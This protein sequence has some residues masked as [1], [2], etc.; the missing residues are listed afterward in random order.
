[1]A[2][3][4]RG[5]PVALARRG[6]AAGAR[7]GRGQHQQPAGD[8]RRRRSTLRRARGGTGAAELSPL[9]ARERAA[10]RPPRPIGRRALPHRRRARLRRGPAVL[11]RGRAPARLRDRLDRGRRRAGGPIQDGAW[12]RTITALCLHLELD[13]LLSN[14]AFGAVAGVLV[15]NSPA[16]ASAGSDPVGRCPRQRAERR[17]ARCRPHRDRRLDR[18]VRSARHPLGPRLE[19]ARRALAGRH[20]PLGA[21]RR[22]HHAAGLSRLRRRAHRHRRARPGLRGRRRDRVL[23]SAAG[24]RLPHGPDAQQVYGAITCGLL[25]LAWLLAL[26]A[27]LYT[28]RRA[29]R[30]ETLLEL[31][32]EHAAPSLRPDRGRRR[33]VGRPHRRDAGRALASM[34]RRPAAGS[35]LAI[36]LELFQHTGSFKPRGALTVDAGLDRRR[37]GAAASRRSAPATTRSPWPW[38]P[39]RLGTSAKVVMPQAAE[40]GTH[41][42]LPALGAEIVLVDG[43]PRRLRRGG[44]H[45]RATKAGR[46]HPFEGQRPPL[47]TATLGARAG[48]PGWAAGRGGRAD[49]RRRPARRH[50]HR[51]Q[52]DR[53]PTVASSASSP[54][55]PTACIAASPPAARRRSSRGAPSPTAWAPLRLPYSF[56]AGRA[57]VDELVLITDARCARRWRC[58]TTS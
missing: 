58:S 17:P 38:P 37:R 10:G 26:R 47:G 48:A 57:H 7:A 52:A 36:K 49:R 55:G 32:A 11:L 21:D 28:D 51:G 8:G 41:R 14:L 19:H 1:M 31:A 9:G 42:Q 2:E 3:L 46:F 54:K 29:N 33:G 23:R 44:A 22:R 18:G 12:W 30:L 4:R 20:P 16:P 43:R 24:H 15:P 27:R 53:S 56:G 13:H 39:R 34:L 45:R 6:R 35:Q 40:P 50:R 5:Q 25:L